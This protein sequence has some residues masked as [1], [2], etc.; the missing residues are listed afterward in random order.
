LFLEKI[1]N[2]ITPQIRLKL[3]Q[4]RAASLGRLHS[5]VILVKPNLTPGNKRDGIEMRKNREKVKDKL[6]NQPGKR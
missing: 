2:K 1:C 3:I 6:K 4:T 5:E